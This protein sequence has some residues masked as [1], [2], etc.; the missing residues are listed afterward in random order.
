MNMWYI[1]G[2]GLEGEIGDKI[3]TVYLPR[4]LMG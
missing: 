4:H 1:Q 2:Y 3:K